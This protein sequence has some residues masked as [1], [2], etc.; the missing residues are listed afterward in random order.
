[1]NNRVASTKIEYERRTLYKDDVFQKF[2]EFYAAP[3]PDKARMFDVPFDQS[4]QRYTFIPGQKDFAKKYGV[5]ANTLTGWKRRSDFIGG[6]DSLQR[7]WGVDVV[8]NVMASLYRRCIKYGMATDV[9]LF[10]AYYKGWDRKQMA[11]APSEKFDMDDIR[12]LLAPLP[13]EKQDE[14]H[15]LI[16][17]IIIEARVYVAN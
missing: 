3:D 5:S 8:P 17:Q 10:L 15:S 9:E 12:A 16:A 4:T 2:V 14:F 6:V 11:K 1:M 13:Q 7:E